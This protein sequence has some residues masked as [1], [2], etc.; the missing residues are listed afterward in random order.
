[1]DNI[2]LMY[3]KHET[4]INIAQTEREL[5]PLLEDILIVRYGTKRIVCE[6]F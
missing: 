1:M 6:L 4:Q 2:S 3:Y 5:L